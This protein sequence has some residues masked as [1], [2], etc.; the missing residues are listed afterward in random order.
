VSVDA[1]YLHAWL[2]AFALT[3]LVEAPLYRLSTKISWFRALSLSAVTH[4]VVWFVIPPLVDGA[5]LEYEHMLGIA[6]FFA[7]T[8]EA[9][10]LRRFGLSWS[11]A[12]LTSL[13][14]NASS[15]AAGLAARA[16]L[17]MP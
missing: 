13:L 4:P 11:R 14:V 17:G 6:E 16:W 1:E 8:A 10:M 7:W 12:L 9:A 3:Q 5:G 15:V 2:L